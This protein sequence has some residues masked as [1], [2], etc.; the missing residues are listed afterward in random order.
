M[1]PKINRNDLLKA[2][3]HLNIYL[4]LFLPENIWNTFV[5]TDEELNSCN[6]F[7]KIFILY[8]YYFHESMTEGS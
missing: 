2:K 8:Y 6:N 5:I 3:D 4:S 1:L 7:Q